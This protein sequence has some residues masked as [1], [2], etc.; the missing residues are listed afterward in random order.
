V[1]G[2]A[3]VSGSSPGGSNPNASRMFLFVLLLIFILYYG[4]YEASAVTVHP[5]Q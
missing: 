5:M 1:F 4:S 3:K 2:D